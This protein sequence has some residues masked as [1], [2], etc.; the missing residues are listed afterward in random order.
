[1]SS[2]FDVVDIARL[3][4]ARSTK[5]NQ[6]D[7]EVLPAW[8]ADMDFDPPPA[9]TEALKGWSADGFL[10][11]PGWAYHKHIH[12][13]ASGY[14]SRR[15]GMVDDPSRYSLLTDVVQGMHAAMQVWSSPGDP[16]LV[17]TPI[18]PPFLSVVGEQKRRL[19]EHRLALVDGEYRFDIDALREQVMEHRPPLLLLCNPHNPVGRVFTIDELRSLGELAVEFNMIVVADEIHAELVFDDRQHLAFETLSEEIRARTITVTSASKSCNLAGLRTAVIVFGS[20]ERKAEFDAVFSSHVLGVV[21]L[22]GMVAMET[23]WSDSS[24]EVWLRECVAALTAR[25]D[26]FAA[27]LSSAFRHVPSQGTY[28]AWV[29]CTPLG[30][31]L[32]E[33]ET[34]ATQLRDEAK[35]AIS[36]GITFGVGLEHFI[37]VNL[38]TSPDIINDILTRLTTW[39]HAAGDAGDGG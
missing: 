18:Y 39:A 6:Y 19:L 1:M 3:R 17:L 32:A 11:Y 21:S 20:M 16:I 38:A 33:Y 23:A 31:T 27:G 28:L 9:I 4:R 5:W 24:V 13:I 34:V 14:L 25:R 8:I 12:V 26:Q 22:P 30:V 37:R 2:P 7:A 10:G 15:F 36:D 35:L 29:D